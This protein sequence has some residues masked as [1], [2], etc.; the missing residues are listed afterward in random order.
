MSLEE[1]QLA[2]RAE[3][4]A[5]RAARDVELEG[6]YRT[7]RDRADAFEAISWEARG[8]VSGKLREFLE[9]VEPYAT[10]AAGEI[11][12]GLASVYVKAL[13]D[14][15]ALWRGFTPPP[16]AG[17]PERPEP[18]VAPLRSR[19]EERAAV[20]VLRRAGF[21]QLLAVRERMEAA[22]RPKDAS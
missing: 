16:V 14:L 11:T 20:E 3:W 9:A 1:Q 18:D 15:A 6:R 8:E 5:W 12:V 2:L 21:D 10:G 13:H 4:E 17:A 19:E 22:R 7:Q